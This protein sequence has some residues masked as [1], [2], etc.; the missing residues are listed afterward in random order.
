MP[1]CTVVM[2][3]ARAPAAAALPIS[4]DEPPW[5]GLALLAVVSA[6]DCPRHPPV[7][8]VADCERVSLN[9]VLDCDAARSSPARMRPDDRS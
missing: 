2:A 1:A 5:P 9:A 8:Q 3:L 4:V 6:T 7:D